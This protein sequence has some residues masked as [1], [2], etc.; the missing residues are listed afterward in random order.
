MLEAR[1]LVKSFGKIAA[2][3]DVSFNARDGQITGLLGPNGAG[4]STTLRMLYTVLTPDAGDAFIDGRLCCTQHPLVLALG[5]HD[6]PGCAP[7]NLEHGLHRG[8]GLIHE[9]AEPLAVFVEALDWTARH[10][11]V[12]GGLRDRRSNVD[13]EPGIERARMETRVRQLDE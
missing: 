5:V 3:R 1:G 11:A 4:K 2:V 13:D 12:H 10:A 7:R 6:A 8:S 9:A